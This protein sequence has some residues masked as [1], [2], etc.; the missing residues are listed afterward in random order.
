MD[1]G[2]WGL[3]A[4]L[5]Y[6]E[7]ETFPH[8]S[9]GDNRDFGE[10]VVGLKGYTRWPGGGRIGLSHCCGMPLSAFQDKGGGKKKEKK[11]AGGQK[12]RHK[13]TGSRI[14]TIKSTYLV[15]TV[16]KSIPLDPSRS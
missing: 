1:G 8:L 7:K 15:K 3:A 2:N 11:M 9:V 10:G 4:T 14:K 12:P 16:I 6:S 5:F 13:N